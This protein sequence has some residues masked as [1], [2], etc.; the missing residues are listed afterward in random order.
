MGAAHFVTGITMLSLTRKTDYALVAMADLAR[1]APM[2]GNTREMSARLRIPL[3]ALRKIMT[4]LM[5]KGLV[6]STRGTEGGYCLERLPE[7]ISLAE[8][9]DAVDGPFKLVL[10]TGRK[11]NCEKKE[12]EMQ[13]GCPVRE[14]IG[15][16]HDL[17]DG[18]LRQVSIAQVASNSI[19]PVLASAS[20]PVGGGAVYMETPRVTR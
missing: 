3:P 17:L 15:K 5:H 10:C 19:P 11:L 14:P 18:V 7:T 12:C 9:I 16:V 20:G 6:V 4:R 2:A 13:E 1:R 8:L